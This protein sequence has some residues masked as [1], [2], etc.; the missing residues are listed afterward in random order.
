MIKTPVFW[1]YLGG[2]FLKRKRLDETLGE[3]YSRIDISKLQDE[4]AK[5]IASQYVQWVDKLNDLYGKDIGWWFSTISSRNT[6]MSRLFQYFCYLEVLERIWQ[7][8]KD[9]LQYIVVE[10]GGLKKAVKKWAEERGIFPRIKSYPSVFF[11]CLF[12]TYFVPFL[13][14]GKFLIELIMRFAAALTVRIFNGKPVLANPPDVIIS[15]YIF[16]YSFG[17]DGSFKDRYFP[18]LYDYLSGRKKNIWVYSLFFGF[19]LNYFSIYRRIKKSQLHFI[20]DEDYLHFGDYCYALGYPFRALGNRLQETRFRIFD[21]S[22]I[23]KEEHFRSLSDGIA[24]SLIYRLFI[25]LGKSG[26]NPSHIIRWYE[27]QVVDKA[28]VMGARKGLPN[29]V[30]VGSQMFIHAPNHLNLFPSQSEAKSG[31]LPDVLLETS[32]YQCRTAQRFTKEFLCK[33]AA[34]LRYVHLFDDSFRRE[35]P[36]KNKKNILVLLP[37]V[38]TE[39]VELLEMVKE[40]VNKTGGRADI[41]IK[42]HPNYNL[43]QLVAAFG[44]TCWPAEFNV[45]E[46]NLSDA[47]KQASAVISSNSS[48]SVEAAARGVP[49]ILIGRQTTLNQN[50]LS[51]FKSEMITECFSV[52]E[53]FAAVN[54]YLDMDTTK[55]QQF[56]ISAKEIRDTFFTSVNEETMSSF[57]FK[58]QQ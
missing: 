14:W 53:C 6:Y 58:K 23:I 57:L 46:G 11:S 15:N 30:I 10:S 33:D 28:V 13:K 2:N 47:L 16:E 25:R 17:K 8:D 48:S 44:K 43:N 27:N 50:S 51:G 55:M 37:F 18:Y 21:V 39:A 36:G 5:D 35:F 29:A 22:D 24:P 52:S 20:L 3:S 42:L 34:A 1:V 19:F 9:K 7:K 40:V 4:V 49:V 32:K 56:E 12:A 26:I 45:F 31:I 54:K 41:L 38:I